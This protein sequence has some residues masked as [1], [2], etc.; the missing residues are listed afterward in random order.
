MFT[1]IPIRGDGNCLFTAVAAA[2]LNTNSNGAL[3][4]GKELRAETSKVVCA[5][6]QSTV[7]QKILKTVGNNVIGPMMD[8]IKQY[9]R[10]STTYAN[11]PVLYVLAHL[12]KRRFVVYTTPI[13]RS[14][15]VQRPSG[16]MRMQ[17]DTAA[18][19]PEIGKRA[20]PIYL[21]RSNSDGLDAH[22][23]LLRPAEL[24]LPL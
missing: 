11:L 3:A 23:E 16:M 9:C 8:D 4:K 10:T 5:K 17:A 1:R 14:N 12:V 18:L 24:L 7:L 21:Y 15:S 19:F 22:Y 13:F 6:R 2:L 20:P